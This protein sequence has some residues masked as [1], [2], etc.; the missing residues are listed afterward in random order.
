M[1]MTVCTASQPGTTRWVLAAPPA[2]P[3]PTPSLKAPAKLKSTSFLA[4]PHIYLCSRYIIGLSNVWTCIKEAFQQ[5][6][7]VSMSVSSMSTAK[8]LYNYIIIKHFLITTAISYLTVY[9]SVRTFHCLH[10]ITYFL[11]AHSALHIAQF[12]QPK[13]YWLS[14]TDYPFDAYVC[15]VTCFRLCNWYLYISGGDRIVWTQQKNMWWG[16]LSVLF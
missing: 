13:A 10:N 5:W 15:L 2:H 8:F 4:G 12:R 14:I 6:C 1:R 16:D 7:L 3:L 11:P 9:K